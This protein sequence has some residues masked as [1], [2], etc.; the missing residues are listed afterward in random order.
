M[1]NENDFENKSKKG[2]IINKSFV[3]KDACLNFPCYLVEIEKLKEQKNFDE[4]DVNI[5]VRIVFKKEKVSVYD[6]GK[7][8]AESIF[9]YVILSDKIFLI[10]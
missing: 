9:F 10:Y 8:I 1:N 4:A 7:E 2:N 6:G 5:L 3:Q